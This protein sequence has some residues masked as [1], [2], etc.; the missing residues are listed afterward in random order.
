[1]AV[2]KFKMRSH[3]WIDSGMVGLFNIAKDREIQEKYDV[4][5][6]LN[7]QE[8]CLE[9]SYRD[10]E[11]LRSFLAECYNVLADR[12]WNVST[13]K[14]KEN[15]EA[16]YY[17]KEKD[18]FVLK[19]KRNP[20][21]IPALFVGARSWRV[22]A[23][24]EYDNLDSTMRQRLDTFM[25]QHNKKLFG[26]KNIL[27]YEPPVCHKEI[28]ILAQKK[29]AVCS[30]CGQEAYGCEEVAQPYYLLFSSNSATK[31]FNSELKQP[32]KI[33]W[34]CQLLS[35]FAVEAA[36]YHKSSAD[37]LYIMQINSTNLAKNINLSEEIGCSSVMRELDQDYFYSNIRVTEKSLVKS[38]ILPFEFLWAF[39]VDSYNTIKA[40]S[41]ADQVGGSFF[42]TELL[43]LMLDRAP[44]QVVL[45]VIA[46]KGDTFLTKEVLYYNDSTYAFRLIHSLIENNVSLRSVFFTLDNKEDLK[47]RSL[48]RNSFFRRVLSKKSV[49]FESEKFAFHIS[50]GDNKPNLS[51]LIEFLKIYETET[52]G[53]TMTKEQVDTAVNLG[54]SIIINAR[55]KISEDK[56]NELKK[57]KGDLFVLR[58]ARTKY[59][60]INQLSR[61]QLRYDLIVSNEILEGILEQVNFEEFKAYCVLG[62]LNLYNSLT[63]NK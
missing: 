50:R 17:D 29:K 4:D 37:S 48:F 59:D 41:R 39:Y 51:H 35:M 1:M 24:E 53:T 11:K 62:A 38:A 9:I 21:P 44:V 8:N 13:K 34:E 56:D 22:V 36:I 52:G 23:G 27:L 40:N 61:M 46:S 54:K 18:E 31:S 28:D 58:K 57:I 42:E 32:D 15:P 10:E 43:G 25:Q 2:I 33:C 45:M 20:A 30:V 26:K 60:F 5:L 49:L 47:N 7:E 6:T 14:Q 3:W 63:V 16:I 55:N 19:A 12:Y